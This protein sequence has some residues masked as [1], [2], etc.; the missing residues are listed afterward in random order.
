MFDLSGCIIRDMPRQRV[1]SAVAR[2]SE[3]VLRDIR[4]FAHLRGVSERQIVDELAQ[5][6]LSEHADELEEFRRLRAKTS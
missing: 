3:D 5:R 4:D 2:I 1:G 6:L